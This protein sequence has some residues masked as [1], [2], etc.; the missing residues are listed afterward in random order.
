MKIRYV[1]EILIFLI[2]AS[3]FI[4]L[5]NRIYT[6]AI[7][8]NIYQNMVKI[9]EEDSFYC[10]LKIDGWECETF[11]KDDVYKKTL[12]QNQEDSKC[13][14]TF[15]EKYDE[16]ADV[17]RFIVCI[18]SDENQTQASISYVKN[19]DKPVN[20]FY[21]FNY[22]E[23]F[24]IG[25]GLKT[26]FENTKNYSVKEL[27]GIC[28]KN[29]SILVTNVSYNNENCYK[30]SWKDSDGL[31]ISKYVSKST[32]LPIAQEIITTSE[33]NEKTSQ[34]AIYEYQTK[35]VTD[36]DVEDPTL[37]NNIN[38]SFMDNYNLSDKN[39]ENVTNQVSISQ[40]PLGENYVENI[41][42]EDDENK[43]LYNVTS[44]EDKIQSILIN[45]YFTYEIVRKDYKNLPE[46]TKEDF[47]SYQVCL[48][49]K[50]GYNLTV[51]D[52]MPSVGSYMNVV[53][54]ADKSDVQTLLLL[55]KPFNES[56]IDRHILELNLVQNIDDIKIDAKKA[57]E[58]A[59]NLLNETKDKYFDEDKIIE[60]S[61][62]KLVNVKISD[63]DFLYK[64]ENLDSNKE[65]GL[66]EQLKR[67]NEATT[68]WLEAFSLKNSDYQ[69]S[70]NVY[71]YIS[72][73]NGDVIGITK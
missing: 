62:D 52:K 33:N 24:V 49:N 26:F 54:N 6:V 64:N 4:F 31:N 28:L 63:L 2:L 27:F 60:K 30:I 23:S 22:S 58:I 65:E 50:N 12:T 36:Q 11:I 10:K 25:A 39:L 72:A 14:Q 37:E 38:I 57:E 44:Q 43:N 48:I 3:L 40:L 61:F 45:N 20:N 34:W 69:E 35:E 55:I 9:S 5:G 16:N 66:I 46:L 29:T 13:I 19:I 70:E 1:L 73:K 68:C 67:D 42:I 56:T 8:N 53:L 21:K 32:N 51:K 41:K 71:V 59:N 17:D 47:D 15:W 18:K 7:I